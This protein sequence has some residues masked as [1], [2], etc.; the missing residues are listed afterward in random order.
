LVVKFIPVVGKSYRISREKLHS[1][2]GF[3]IIEVAIGSVVLMGA[4]VSTLFA[5]STGFRLLE[6]ARNTTLADQ[7]LQSAIEDIR[8]YSYTQ[9]KALAASSTW[10]DDASGFQVTRTVADTSYK[11]ATT[12]LVNMKKITISVTWKSFTKQ[13]KTR[14]YQTLFSEHGLTDY[15]VPTH[16]T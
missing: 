5:L 1:S 9:I 13:Q 2:R 11:D 14:T 3:T 6:A 16:S 7:V 8:L 12:G 4:F 10:T 15:Y